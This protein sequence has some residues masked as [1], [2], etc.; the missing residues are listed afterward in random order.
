MLR[1]EGCPL[2]VYWN[3]PSVSS[4]RLSCEGPLVGVP[5]QALVEGLEGCDMSALEWRWERS[6]DKDHQVWESCECPQLVY[7]PTDHDQGC[8]LRVHCAVPFPGDACVSQ[9]SKLAVWTP[10]RPPVWWCG[11]CAK[12]KGLHFRL[13]TYNLSADAFTS[14]NPLLS[15]CSKEALSAARRR[16]LVLRDICGLGPDII[17][18]CSP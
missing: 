16:Q 14:K 6:C 1:V 18:G 9:P 3:P 5:M 7:I 2:V 17:V 12:P 11:L 15:Y 10:P 13:C 8:F 4:V